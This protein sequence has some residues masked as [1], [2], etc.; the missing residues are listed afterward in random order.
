[1]YVLLQRSDMFTGLRIAHVR[2]LFK[3]PELYRIQTSHPLAYIEWFT[4]FGAQ[5]D[6]SSGLYSITRSTRQHRPYA[7]IIEVTRI[8]RN[9]HVVPKFGRL[10][11][12]TWTS[13]N[14]TDL[15]N[16]FFVNHHIDL[17]MFCMIQIG[18]FGCT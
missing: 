15:C 14:V 5:T 11:D 18:F 2:V 4:P 13:E 7:E 17:H 16:S 8:V 12:P 10:K 9:C 1:M 3:L 6:P